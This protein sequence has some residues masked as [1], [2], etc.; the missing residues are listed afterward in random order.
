MKTRIALLALAAVAL[1]LPTALSAAEKPLPSAELVY[2]ENNSRQFRVTDANGSPATAKEGMKL[3]VGWTVKTGKGDT[4][5]IE[6]THNRTIIKVSQNTTFTVK[7]LG[8]TKETPNV[9][10]VAVGKIRTVAGRASGNERYRIEGGAAVCGVS[11]TDFIFTVP[12]NG[13]DAILQTLEG[14]VEFWKEN[15]P[16]SI[17]QVGA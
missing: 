6:L 1:V 15:D 4:A 16:G 14:L 17:L 8:D 2:F 12:E 11:G 10:S 3:G 13:A 5:E 7:A 9:M